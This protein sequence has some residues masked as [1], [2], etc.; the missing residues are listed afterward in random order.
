[1][2]IVMHTQTAS[3][4]EHKLILAHVFTGKSKDFGGE[5]EP[6]LQVSSYMQC[7]Q[8]WFLVSLT[9]YCYENEKHKCVRLTTRTKSTR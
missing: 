9:V 4:S 8:K 7:I 1:M 3:R 6:T 2:L 5:F